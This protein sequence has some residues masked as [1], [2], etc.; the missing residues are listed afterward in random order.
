MTE[1]KSAD[2]KKIL[3][4]QATLVRVMEAKLK[5]LEPRTASLDEMVGRIEQAYQAAD[6]LPEDL[7][8]LTEAR[9]KISELV[10]K[11]TQDQE[12]VE[13]IK[14]VTDELDKQLKT[15]AEEANDV[16]RRCESAYSAATSVGLAAAFSERSR[17]LSKSMWFWIGSLIIALAVGSI[18]GSSQ[19][20]TLSYLIE[21][22]TSSTSAIVLNMFMSM[23]TVGAPIWFAWLA[24]KQ[25]GQ[26]FRL[27]EDYAFKASVSRAYEGF[28]REAASFDKE[29]EAKLLT[30]A[31][32]RLD[33]LP[34]RLVEI[35]SHG[36]PWHELASSDVVKKAMRDVPGF[37]AEII[38]LARNKIGSNMPSKEK[39]KPTKQP[40]QT[41][42]E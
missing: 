5:D 30:S 34:L 10:S 19:L 27:S 38:R 33:E 2:L 12:E 14:K 26:R 20:G 25:I 7:Q 11:A 15:I 40:V 21:H 42:E 8:S 3:R 31:L 41:E 29:M 18:F 1:D 28:R 24:T 4:N 32:T 9:T 36:S 16:I 17:E 23:L 39:T 13:G 22:S 35:Q 37:S 6:Q